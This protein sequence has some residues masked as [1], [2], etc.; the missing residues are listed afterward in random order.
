L[1]SQLQ[2]LSDSREPIARIWANKT[3]TM[4]DLADLARETNLKQGEERE[5]GKAKLES[6]MGAEFF[7][8][9]FTWAAEEALD[10]I[11]KQDPKS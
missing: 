9:D 5:A 3:L 7:G 10:W 1:R 11:T 2:E 4:L 6:Y 8:E